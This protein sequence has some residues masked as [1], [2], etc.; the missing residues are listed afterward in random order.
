MSAVVLEVTLGLVVEG[1][2]IIL[3]HDYL[4]FRHN[5]LLLNILSMVTNFREFTVREK[6]G[7][8]LLLEY[9]IYQMAIDHKAL[10]LL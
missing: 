4:K 9:F 1:L 2:I 3:G 6:L 5:F 7:Y 8:L 10:E